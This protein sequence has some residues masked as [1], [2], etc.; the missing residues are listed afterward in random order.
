MQ[1]VQLVRK[2]RSSRACEGWKRQPTFDICL[3]ELANTLQLERAGY[4][5][6]QKLQRRSV[7]NQIWDMGV[8]M[9]SERRLMA[10]TDLDVFIITYTSFIYF[11]M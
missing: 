7:V 9:S 1:K 5:N 4:S 3:S 10:A 2:E 11:D 6:D 8:K